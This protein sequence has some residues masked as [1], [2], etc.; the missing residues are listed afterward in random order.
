MRVM[1]LVTDL[2]RGGTPLRI[3]RLACGLRAAGADVSAGCLAPPGPVSAELEARGIDTFS[4]AARDAR[5]VR[6]LQR[7]ARQVRRLRPDLIHATLTHANVAAR[8]VGLVCHVPVLTSTATI[9]VERRWHRWAELLTARL[10]R[11]H[12]VNS[13]TLA[14]HVAEAFWLPERH[15]HV[16][17][18]LLAPVPRRTE[19]AAARERLGIPAHEFVV[20][21]VGRLDPVKRIDLIVR[22]AEIMGVVPCR[23][24]LAGD[25]PQRPAVEQMVRLSSS[26][27]RLHLLGWQT[28][29]GPLLS[30]ADAFLFPSLTE[31]MPNAVL[32]AMQFGLPVVGSDVPTLRELSGAGTRLMLVESAEPKAFADALLW[33]R[34]NDDHRL[35]LGQRAAAWVAGVGDSR[36][37]VWA[38]LGVYRR[39]V[40][41]R[42]W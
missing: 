6:A 10:D 34:E 27:P 20:L 33:L 39:V 40:P 24:L 36:V 38:V 18:P 9:E 2:E 14:R 21:W 17:P 29:L 42:R 1:L 26:A 13:E 31:G 23:F 41:R 19:R 8:V 37:A 3:A 35:A 22:C 11:G 28:G 4:C 25:G 32:E 5:D 30:A 7:L 12:I 15:I 16:V